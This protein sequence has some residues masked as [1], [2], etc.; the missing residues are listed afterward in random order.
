MIQDIAKV[1]E[2]SF[3]GIAILPDT[4]IKHEDFSA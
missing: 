3:L 1:T 2:I 4:V